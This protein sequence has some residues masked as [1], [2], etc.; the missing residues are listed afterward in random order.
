MSDY[1]P[2]EK[3]E[4][5]IDSKC[6]VCL[7]DYGMHLTEENA[8]R[9]KLKAHCFACS[10]RVRSALMKESDESV[11]SWF[12]SLRKDDLEEYRKAVMWLELLKS[13]DLRSDIQKLEI[14]EAWPLNAEPLK[15]NKKL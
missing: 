6:C 12:K 14:L 8:G 9:Y 15:L 13:G 10:G 11:K 5:E 1:V 3:A 4:E 7:Q 2:P